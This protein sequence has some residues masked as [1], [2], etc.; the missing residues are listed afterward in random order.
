MDASP[1]Q[2]ATLDYSQIASVAWE[3]MRFYA[4]TEGLIDRTWELLTPEE[5]E[6]ERQTVAQ[7]LAYP[8][9]TPEKC[10]KIMVE[11]AEKAGWKFGYLHDAEKKESP[12]LVP[13][14]ELPRVIRYKEAL[15]WHTIVSIGIAAGKVNGEKLNQILALEAAQELEAFE[16][17]LTDGQ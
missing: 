4:F 5:K 15:Y 6:R 8:E 9:V 17:E 3:V 11:E 12:E 2:H 16:K 10:H 7:Y 1:Y 14:D 13:W